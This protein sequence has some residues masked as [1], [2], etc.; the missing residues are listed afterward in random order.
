[1]KK[2]LFSFFIIL[3]LLPLSLE[4][5]EVKKDVYKNELYSFQAQL[6]NGWI[7]SFAQ[8]DGAILKTTNITSQGAIG[9]ISIYAKNLPPLS[10]SYSKLDAQLLEKILD[11]EVANLKKEKSDATINYSR[12]IDIGGNRFLVLYYSYGNEKNKTQIITSKT[13]SN[14]IQYNLLL[15]TNDQTDS[16]INEYYKVLT[17]FQTLI[18][19]EADPNNIQI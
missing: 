15:E 12:Y 5:K 19:T 3:F 9:S 17:S 4:A 14:N 7:T 6:P 13:I 8:S 11:E 2:L 10:A 1:M 16:M 18:V